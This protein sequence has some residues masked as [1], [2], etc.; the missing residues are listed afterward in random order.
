MAYGVS[1]GDVYPPY[2][3]YMCKWWR[4]LSMHVGCHAWVCLMFRLH[5]TQKSTVNYLPSQALSNASL[6][7]GGGKGLV[8][9]GQVFGVGAD[10]EGLVVEGA[11]GGVMGV[12]Y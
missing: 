2:G 9:L 3:I 10:G 12:H 5:Q 1:S 11:D 6:L 7:S 8:W 4:P